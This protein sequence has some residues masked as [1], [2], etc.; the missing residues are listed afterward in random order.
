MTLATQLRQAVDTIIAQQKQIQ[1]GEY[2][3]AVEASV[4]RDSAPG[5]P[6]EVAPTPLVRCFWVNDEFTEYKRVVCFSIVGDETPTCD[7]LEVVRLSK[8]VDV[9]KK[10]LGDDCLLALHMPNDRDVAQAYMKK[11]G[12][13]NKMLEICDPSGAFSLA[14]GIAFNGFTA[15]PD[16]NRHLQLVVPHRTWTYWETEVVCEGAEKV[17]RS[18][19]KYLEQEEKKEGKGDKVCENNDPKA[20]LKK[21]QSLPVKSTASSVAGIR[22]DSDEKKAKA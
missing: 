1:V 15:G 4:R 14:L 10:A 5:V 9:L 20:V 18:V 22:V 16:K 3:P 12:L 11:H 8:Y 19:L 6:G 17:K 2:A 13:H 21:I 7:G